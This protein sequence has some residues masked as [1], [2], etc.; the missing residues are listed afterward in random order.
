MNANGAYVPAE[1]PQTSSGTNN[2][3]GA[4]G[5]GTIVTAEGS[6]TAFGV[7]PPALGVQFIIKT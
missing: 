7:V 1:A 4:Q 3:Q 6:G 5:S 2:L